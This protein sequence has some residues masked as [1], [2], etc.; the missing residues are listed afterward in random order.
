MANIY[1]GHVQEHVQRAILLLIEQTGQVEPDAVFARCPRTDGRDIS[2]A[3]EVLL[4]EGS[5]DHGQGSFAH[6]WP[7]ITEKGRWRL[8][9]F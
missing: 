6:G 3:I 1:P 5:L 2:R 7:R 8:T 9:A 4:D